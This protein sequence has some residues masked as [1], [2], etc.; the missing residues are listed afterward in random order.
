MHFKVLA[1]ACLV[2]LAACEKHASALATD[3]VTDALIAKRPA[4]E[5]LTYGGDREEQRFSPLDAINDGN[6]KDL[7]LA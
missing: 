1:L 7:G 5:W 3:G 2:A 6:V 4:G